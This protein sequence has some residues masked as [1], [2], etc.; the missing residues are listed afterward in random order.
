MVLTLIVT[1]VAKDFASLFGVG[2]D[3]GQVVSSYFLMI[4][5]G[6]VCNIITNSMLGVINGA[7]KPAAAMCLMIFY[8]I[9]VRIHSRGVADERIQPRLLEENK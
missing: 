2:D 8:Y 9:V 1:L 6:Y 4:A 5:F 7:G 3:A